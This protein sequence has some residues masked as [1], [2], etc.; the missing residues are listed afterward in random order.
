M[1]AN[2]ASSP[3]ERRRTVIIRATSDTLP[4]A[5]MKV[6]GLTPVERAVRQWSRLPGVRIVVLSAAHDDEV[7][8]RFNVFRV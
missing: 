1:S 4:G 6:A 2:P 3:G 5:A 8:L 7:G